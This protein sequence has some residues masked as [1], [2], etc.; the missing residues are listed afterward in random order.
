MATSVQ[1]LCRTHED[2]SY[3]DGPHSSGAP[4]GRHSA[5]GLKM[6]VVSEREVGYVCIDGNLPERVNTICRGWGN[7]TRIARRTRTY[8]VD[9]RGH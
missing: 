4:V 1:D 9:L 5:F 7:I 2:H 8:I 3:R 6:R